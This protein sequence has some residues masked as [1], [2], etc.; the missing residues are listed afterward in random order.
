[1]AFLPHPPDGQWIDPKTGH[2]N[3][4]AYN[5]L[6]LL[7]DRLGGLSN[8]VLPDYVGGTGVTNVAE[9]VAAQEASTVQ[10]SGTYQLETLADVTLLRPA[11]AVFGDSEVTTIAW[12][13]PFADTSYNIT[14]SSSL[15]QG[16]IGAPFN[17]TVNGF[18]IELTNTSS[19][20]SARG[21]ITATGVH[22]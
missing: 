22:A 12:D 8:A 6:I 18:D 1:M 2:I 5:W 20:A 11:S 17:I 4:H 10:S 21:S 7:H 15:V 13:N 3:R 14:I 19:H 9:L 16:A